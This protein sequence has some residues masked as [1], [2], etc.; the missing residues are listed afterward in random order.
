MVVHFSDLSVL[1]TPEAHKVYL[2]VSNTAKAFVC[3]FYNCIL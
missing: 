3:V 2:L 1:V